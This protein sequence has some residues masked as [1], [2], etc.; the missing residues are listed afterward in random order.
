MRNDVKACPVSAMQETE[1]VTFST[2]FK[3]SVESKSAKICRESHDNDDHED[4]TA[5]T[6]SST[7]TAIKVS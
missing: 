6:G 1:L 3:L 2:K 5:N 7:D 4:K